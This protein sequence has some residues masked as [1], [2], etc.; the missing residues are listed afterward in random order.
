E[1]LGDG[2]HLPVQPVAEGHLF[3]VEVARPLDGLDDRHLVAP[4][5]QTTSADRR[6]RSED[7]QR[8]SAV[9]ASSWADGHGD[10][11]SDRSCAS[12]FEIGAKY[13]RAAAIFQAF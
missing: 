8:Y 10:G 5:S 11:A 2:A 7:S 6:P 1:A 4:V 9:N 3:R 13:T 12:L